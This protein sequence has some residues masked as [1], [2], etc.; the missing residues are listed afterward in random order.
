MPSCSEQFP[1]DVVFALPDQANAGET[2]AALDFVKTVTDD[3][4]FGPVQMQVGLTPRQ[5]TV[6]NT[7]SPALQEI[8]L[9]EHDTNEGFNA[10][11]E[12]RKLAGTPTHLHLQYLN[13]QAF[14]EQNGGRIDAVRFGVLVID[15]V[16]ENWQE[17]LKYA[18]FAKEDGTRLIVVVVGNV[19]GMKREA[20]QLA[21]SVSDV[22]YA[23]SYDDLNQQK[24]K[25]I[26]RICAGMKASNGAMERRY[27]DMRQVFRRFKES[28]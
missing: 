6:G 24:D 27:S 4:I 7:D 19:R 11:L 10:R 22:I 26:N 21:S 13:S 14:S 15:N 20:K 8:K 28:L 25:L 3:M 23:K 2:D 1:G 12:D 18:D 17:T 5:C 16:A 9:K